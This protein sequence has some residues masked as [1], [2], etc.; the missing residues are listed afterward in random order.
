M[1]EFLKTVVSFS[2]TAAALTFTAATGSDYFTLD[3]ADGRVTLLFANAG[4]QTA[5][6]VIQAGDGTLASLG[7]VAVTVEP[8][9]TLAV[10]MARLA[11]AR[12]KRLSGDDRG[13]VV[14]TSSMAG[15]APAGLSA[16]VLSVA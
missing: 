5:G 9:K 7:G 4:A 16:A 13:K 2:E 6:V 11:S 15:A 3:N 8:G 1:S 12:V 10:P 14:V